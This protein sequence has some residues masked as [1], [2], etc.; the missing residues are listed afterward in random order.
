M[1]DAADRAMYRT[2]M[3]D[4]LE[5]EMNIRTKKHKDFRGWVGQQLDLAKRMKIVGR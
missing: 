4:Q 2:M 3:E 5:N 1:E